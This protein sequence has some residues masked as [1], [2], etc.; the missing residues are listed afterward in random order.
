MGKRGVVLIVTCMIIS[1]LLVLTAVL[2]S[3]LFTQ[4]R[5]VDT[6]K[7]SLQAINLAEA[8]AGH[9][10][11]ELRDRIRV[12][13]S[14][15]MIGVKQ[16]NVI[17]NYANADNSLLFLR[18]YA[19]PD[20]GS[21]F[22][23]SGGQATL[24]VTS[25]TL[26]SS[27][28]G[29]YSARIIIKAD[30][31]PSNTSTDVYVFPYTFT[32]E[33]QGNVSS[34][35]PA[36][37]KNIRLLQGAFSLTVR[38]D[39]FAKF[40]LFTAHHRTPNNTTVWFTSN[41]N[42]NGPV[43]TNETLSFANNLSAHFTEEVSQHQNRARYYNNGSTVLLDAD[44]NAACCEAVGCETI[45]CKDKPVFDKGFQRGADE[46]NLQSSVSQSDLKQQALGTMTEPGQNGVYVANDGSTLTGGIYIRGDSGV[47]MSVDA[48]N[49][50]VYTITQ[51][52][53]TNVITVNYG[54]NQTTVTSG[55]Q[56]QTYSGIPNG[57][58]N[59]G[60]L[61]YAK[62]DITSFS[63]V[64]Q[65]ATAATVSSENDIT[66]TG[67]VTYQQYN[68]GPPVNAEGYQNVLGILAWNGDVSIG[69]SAPDNINI[70]GI[71][72]APRGV[73]TVDNYNIG[74]TRGVATLL[75]GV[76]TD[77]YGAFGTFSGNSNI[78]GYGRNFVYDA[79]MLQGL[80][81]PYFPYM[82]NFTS[83]DGKATSGGK[84]LDNKLVWQDEGV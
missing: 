9:A 71:V 16:S 78:S 20:G 58:G 63:G 72:M 2:F 54:T 81:P 43:Y 41:T 27:V 56:T 60:V 57:V 13:L 29:N 84:G 49:N 40:A 62:D 77:F 37:S 17:Q 8:G 68:A 76:I 51:G 73:F 80:T 42:F 55:T 7:F 53:T 14:G 67:N 66:I 5:S 1:V 4:K 24:T 15:R 30:G 65:S 12:D 44:S 38:R 3:G 23:V 19:Y 64:V 35:N 45:P 69:T 22:S 11:S 50:P 25:G 52:S 31:A 46:I 47:V 36:V 10:L 83:V 79:R 33:S 18:D 28:Q 39:S 26:N 32:I 59:E 70:H 48:S 6:Q 21:Q 75:G 74:G 61:I 82:S 34:V